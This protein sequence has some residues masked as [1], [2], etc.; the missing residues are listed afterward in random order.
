[1]AQS[2]L[3]RST[4]VFTVSVWW[5][6]HTQGLLVAADNDVIA[7]YMPVSDVVEH[8]EIDLDMAEMETAADLE[9]DAGFLDAFN[10]YNIGGNSVK[11]DS[12]RTIRGFSTSAEEKLTGEPWFD[13]Y[14]SYWGSPTYADDFTSAACNGEGAFEDVEAVVRAEGCVKGAQY[15][16]VWM[17]VIHEMEDAISDCKKG[18]LTANDGGPHAWDEGWAFYAGSLEEVDGSGDGKLLYALADKRCENFK[19]C[20]GDEDGNDLSGTAAVNKE[21]L[22]LFRE[23][24]QYLLDG[25]C[26]DV[27][28]IKDKIVDLMTIPL[29]QGLLRYVYLAD[30][31]GGQGADKEAA[32]LWAFSAAVLPRIHECNE[33][34]ASI[35]EANTNIESID[36]PVSDG[37]VEIKA[38]IE[39]VY[40]CLG[41]TCDDVGGLLMEGATS[42][43]SG[44]EP[45]KSSGG[46]DLSAGEIAGI[47]IVVVAVVGIIGFCL[48][49]SRRKSKGVDHSAGDVGLGGFGNKG[50]TSTL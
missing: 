35:I 21:I 27:T 15:Q 38:Q 18:D 44:M 34:V 48:Y 45:C 14:E 37:Y 23:G 42:Y 6:L 13:V 16:N 49:R 9:T 3:T 33:D 46:E 2:L 30:P 5:R 11:T 26:D 7:G 10:V 29:V 28:A 25:N 32:E 39:K 22:E 40:E 43:V 12:N 24:V 41:M 19:T 31:Q 4:L 50:A 17:Y 47:S 20:S 8:S 1:M 36:A